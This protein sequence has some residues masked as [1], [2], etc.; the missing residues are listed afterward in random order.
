[1]SDRLLLRVY[2]DSLS[3]P[4]PA[5]GVLHGDV[6]PELI[7]DALEATY[8][9][10]RVSVWNRSRGGASIADLHDSYRQDSAYFDP[11]EPSILVIQ[12][13]IVDCAPRPV[14][15]SVREKIGRLPTPLRWLVAK[16]LHFARP[17]LLRAGIRW[18]ATEG[19]DFETRLLAWIK[20]ARTG[21]TRVYVVNIAPTIPT[22]DAHSPGLADSIHDYNA[23][24][25][26]AASAGGGTL[27]DV[28]GAI[29]AQP[30]GIDGHINPRDGH[31][32]SRQGHRLYA[33]LL[34]AAE[35]AAV[36]R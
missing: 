29:R 9:G 24:I 17:F 5:D 27:I 13:G 11:I 28:F 26:R 4:R 18:R 15:P 8:S 34:L 16:I 35:A 7:R 31:H 1:M 32:I 19:H 21:A 36:T 20:A 22:I 12:C 25:R 2:G 3:L 33:D 6:Y 30:E 10:L 23:A 14:P